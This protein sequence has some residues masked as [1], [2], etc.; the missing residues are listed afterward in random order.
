VSVLRGGF[1]VFFVLSG[2]L[3]TSL[4]VADRRDARPDVCATGL[5]GGAPIG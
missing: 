1:L 2:F 4:L 3:I 5:H